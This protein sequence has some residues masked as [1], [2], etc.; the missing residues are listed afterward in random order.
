MNLRK[1]RFL[2]NTISLIGLLIL[3]YILFYPAVNKS[4]T[5]GRDS[6]VFLYIA[7]QIREG[8]I[9]YLQLWDHK[10]P[11]IYYIDILGLS[12]GKGQIWGVNIVELLFISL[13]IIFAFI[14]LRKVF[15]LI[16]SILSIIILQLM[17]YRV[18]EGGN[19]T[20]EYGVLFQ[21]LIIL[22]FY[23]TVK[24]KKLFLYFIIGVF[25]GLLFF[26]KQNLIGG[27]IT[28]VIFL[29][30]YRLFKNNCLYFLK[31]I[32]LLI[33]GC[34]LVAVSMFIYFYFTGSLADFISSTILYNFY[35]SKDAH[36]QLLNVFIHAVNSLN[37]WLLLAIIGYAELY[38]ILKNNQ[39]LKKENVDITFFYHFLF[40]LFPVEILMVSV[41]GR[42]YPHYYMSLTPVVTLLTAF[43]LTKIIKAVNTTK[44][45]QNIHVTNYISL[46]VLFAIIGII[47]LNL[48]GTPHISLWNFK[49]F[50]QPKVNI[51]EFIDSN[52]TPNDYV[53]FWGANTSYNFASQ[54]KS[55]T[56]YF[57]QYPLL[58][59]GYQNNEMID[60]F[61]RDI[62]IN[63]PKFIIDD[64]VSDEISPDI[65]CPRTSNNQPDGSIYYFPEEM[66]KAVSFICQNYH[67]AGEVESRWIIYQLNN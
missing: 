52:S 36:W 15:G 34:L 39:G 65:T 4:I 22:L 12:L 17:Y 51:T 11:L 47:Y 43:L 23:L 27:F 63:K 9:P 13:S 61:T 49:G 46:V 55:P 60:Q 5:P 28:V 58:T 6:G 33:G 50:N 64:K 38:T 16:P 62:I 8:Q 40:I 42:T 56:K 26:L 59:R 32:N 45:N 1:I 19:L 20:E 67:K 41:S 37:Y 31:K 29:L 14:L 48:K 35:Y 25:G 3:N 54:R 2:L 57:Y 53:L 30:Y 66:N 24:T 44:T 21:F 7:Q 18:L 10:P